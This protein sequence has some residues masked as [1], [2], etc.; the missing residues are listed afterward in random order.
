MIQF[1][2]IDFKELA[3]SWAATHKEKFNKDNILIIHTYIQRRHEMRKNRDFVYIHH[4]IF[5]TILPSKQA[6]A[7]KKFM[8]EHNLIETDNH[9]MVGEKSKG[10]RIPDHMKGYNLVELEGK[11]AEKRW[12]KYKKAQMEL[13]QQ[14]R[15]RDLVYYTLCSHTE[16]V[17]F[18]MAAAMADVEQLYA[19]GVIYS[20]EQYDTQMMAAQL[21]EMDRQI[22][23]KDVFGNRMHTAVTSLPKYMR[24]HLQYQDG[25]LVEVYI[26][27]SQ[28]YFLAQVLR[29]HRVKGFEK[30]NRLLAE[31]GK[32]P[33]VEN[34][35]FLAENGMLYEFVQEEPGL[36]NR[37]KAKSFV[38]HCLF[39]DA[40]MWILKEK[41]AK[42]ATLFPSLI[43]LADMVN[44]IHADLARRL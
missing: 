25:K 30:Y 13:L 7:Y 3:V 1:K 6:D 19:K 38:F 29:G 4:N 24:K 37:G 40:S 5:R 35:I 11:A 16:R 28:L 39:S 9:Y 36:E 2:Q 23:P 43:E 26:K 14:E 8:L 22:R 32:R 15:T 33:N 41:K 42:F 27:N 12:K 18:D 31:I 21:F 17:S 44:A 20:Q 34:F 10:Y